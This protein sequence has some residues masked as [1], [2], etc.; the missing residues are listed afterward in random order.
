MCSVINRL[1]GIASECS[2]DVD[3]LRLMLGLMA[4]RA[5]ETHT[6]DGHISTS[7]P[8]KYVLELVHNREKIS[9]DFI[10]VITQACKYTVVYLMVASCEF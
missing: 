8:F 2:V 5:Q 4:R 10:Q 3:L 9:S 6:Q 1:D 7:T